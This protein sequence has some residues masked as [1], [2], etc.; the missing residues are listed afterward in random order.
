MTLGDQL[1]VGDL[2]APPGVTI[3]LE[4]SELVAQISVPRGLATAEGDAGEG[5]EAVGGTETASE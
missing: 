5:V 4:A 2:V 1:H 3:A